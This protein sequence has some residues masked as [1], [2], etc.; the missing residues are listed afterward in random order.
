[1]GMG[2]FLANDNCQHYAPDLSALLSTALGLQSSSRNDLFP[3]AR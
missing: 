3:I 1:M 2:A